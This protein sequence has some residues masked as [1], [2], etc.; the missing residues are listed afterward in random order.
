MQEAGSKELIISNALKDARDK[1][2]IALKLTLKASKVEKVIHMVLKKTF[3]FN[4]KL[5]R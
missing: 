2:V 3:L 4:E 5:A 1:L